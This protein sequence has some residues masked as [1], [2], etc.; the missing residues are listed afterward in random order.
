[1]AFS[2][3]DATTLMKIRDDLISII[4]GQFQLTFLNAFNNYSPYHEPANYF[5]R[6][7]FYGVDKTINLLQGTQDHS[8]REDLKQQINYNCNIASK[9]LEECYNINLTES[10][11]FSR[12]FKSDY[13]ECLKMPQNIGPNPILVIM[14]QQWRIKLN[15][16]KTT[17]VFFSR[18]FDYPNGLTINNTTVSGFDEGKYL[19]VIIDKTHP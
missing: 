9:I 6:D 7:I 18:S 14:C 17:A 1:M 13:I 15:E 11:A 16:N 4:T 5:L 2:P 10:F 19:G 3:N 8:T 12:Y